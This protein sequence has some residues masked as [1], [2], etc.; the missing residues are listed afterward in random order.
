METPS[1]TVILDRAPVMADPGQMSDDGPRRPDPEV[2]GRAR[3]RTF[4]AR[5]DAGIPGRLR[6]RG[7]G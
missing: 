6:C 2:P 7:R 5:Y 3:R 1:M 4:T